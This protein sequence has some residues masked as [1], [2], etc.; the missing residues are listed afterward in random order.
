MGEGTQTDGQTNYRVAA[1]LKNKKG[2]K[3]R[4]AA[5]LKIG[6]IDHNIKVPNK[7]RYIM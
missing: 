2:V 5:Q 7:L 4:V 1:Q 6:N 3:Y